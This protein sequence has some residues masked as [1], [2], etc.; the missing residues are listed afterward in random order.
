MKCVAKQIYEIIKKNK[1]LFVLTCLID[2]MAYGF[3][4]TTYTFNV[5]QLVPEYYNGSILITAGRY[6]S[7][8]IHNVTNWFTFSPFWATVVMCIFFIFS[9]LLTAVL[10][11]KETDNGYTSISLFLFIMIFESFPAISAQLTY[12]NINI[13]ISYCV[14]PIALM[15]LKPFDNKVSIKGFLLSSLLISFAIDMYESFAPVT[16]TLFFGLFLLK[17]F[18][19]K[20]KLSFKNDFLLP[21]IK[22]AMML[23]AGIILEFI[24]SKSVCKLVSGEFEYW[25]TENTYIAWID[26][27]AGILRCFKRLLVELLSFIV[28]GSAVDL[29]CF[30]FTASVS[31][32]FLLAI[33][34]TVKSKGQNGILMFLGAVAVTASAKSLQLVTGRLEETRQLQAIPVFCAII[35]LLLCENLIKHKYAAFKVAAIAGFVLALSVQTQYMNNVAVK[36]YE[37]FDYEIDILKEVR[38]ELKKYDTENKAVSFAAQEDF[39]LPEVLTSSDEPPIIAKMYKRFIYCLWNTCIPENFGKAEDFEK[40]Y[41]NNNVTQWSYISWI[42]GVKRFPVVYRT[43]ERLGLKLIQPEVIS[44][45][46]AEEY[47]FEKGEEFKIIDNEDEIYVIFGTKST[48]T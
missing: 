14:V 43:F 42:C 17:I 7:P 5:D 38:D 19:A 11:N 4:A 16:L 48:S 12:P 47:I 34:K 32:L 22:V 6:F 45:I 36:N 10:I 29:S 25:Y 28:I 9:G 18:N 35:A 21:T 44:E 39:E 40:Q 8:L 33:V 3:Y 15:I 30:C 2:V 24:V 46:D 41:T 13:A 23:V 27:S 37:R 31:I 26:S 1:L 20:V